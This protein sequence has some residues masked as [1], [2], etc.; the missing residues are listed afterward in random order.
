MRC[1]M[2]EDLVCGREIDQENTRFFTEYDG[3]MYYFCS[4]ECKRE[5]DDHPDSFIQENARKQLGI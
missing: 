1:R 4:A 3:G 5:F 2:A